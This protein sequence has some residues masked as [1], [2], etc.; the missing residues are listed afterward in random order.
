METVAPFAGR[1]ATGNVVQV[2]R[3]TEVVD[4]MSDPFRELEHLRKLAA[5][6]PRKRFSR[7]YRL[8][9]QVGV[10]AAAAK[11]VRQN[12]GGRTAGIDGQTRRQIGAE[13]LTDL[14]D[15]LTHGRYRAKAV[16][17]AYI[18]KGKTG[19][20]ALGIPTIRDRIVQA[21]V[22]QVLEAIY[23]PIFRSCSNGFR[24]RRSTI[25]CL[26]HVAQAYKAGATWIIEGDLVKCFDSIPHGVIL[27]CLRKRI[28]DERFIDLI[29]QMLQ[30]GVIEEGSYTRTYSGTPQGGLCSPMIS[31]IVLHE[32]DCWMEHHW[33]ANKLQTIQEQQKRA[34]PEYARHK[35]NLVRW[36]AQLNGR[37]PMGRQTEI[38]LKAKI[39][40]ALQERSRLPC[41]LPRK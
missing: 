22:A 41:Y 3:G 33:Q 8:V 30:A 11:R 14:A 37:I 10:L 34:N 38:G 26:R 24:P 25:E 40:Q 12:T 27:D 17:R 39:K 16:R 32:F 28:K 15:D 23:E 21:A 13:M 31:N 2:P 19:R 4:L 29:R 20:R 9:R 1:R 35:R 18:P 5:T 6:H 7:L 36:R